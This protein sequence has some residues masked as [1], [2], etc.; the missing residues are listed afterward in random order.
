[1][2]E[3]RKILVVYEGLQYGRAREHHSFVHLQDC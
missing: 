2:R 3:L 1:M